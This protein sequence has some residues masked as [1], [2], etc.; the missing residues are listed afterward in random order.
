MIYARFSLDMQNEISLE[1]QEIVCCEAIGQRGG[2][3]IGVYKDRAEHGWSLDRDEFKQMQKAAE[4]G[5]FDALMVWKFD[6]LA[7]DHDHAVMI[8]MLLRHEYGLK[9]H[10][11]EGFSEDDDDGPYAAMM[12]QMLAVFSAFFSRNLSTET[13]R[14]TTEVSRQLAISSFPWRKEQKNVRAGCTS[15][16]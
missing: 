4:M 7:R 2:V 5:R 10:C 13:K 11:V 14:T 1:D 15:T 9:L 3:V 8:K 12:E 16:R 6:R